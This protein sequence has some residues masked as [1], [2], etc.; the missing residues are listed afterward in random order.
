MQESPTPRNFIADI[1][2]TDLESGRHKGVVT[3]FP[4]EPNGYLH[5]GHAKSI[6]LNF[7]LARAFGGACHLRFDDTNPST[8]DLEYVEAI[9]RDVR[10]LGFDWGPN[11]FFA[12]DYYEA[13]YEHALHLIR[14]GFAY[15]CSLSDAGVKAGRGS[16]SEPGVDSPYRG[17]SVEENLALFERM[18]LGEFEDGAHVLRAKIDMAAANMKL[19]DPAIYRIKHA[20]H[21]RRGKDWC[22][23]P[24]Y[25]FAH[26]LSDAQ[27]GITHSICTLEF[28]NNRELYDW[29]LARSVVD[30]RPRQ[31]EFARLNLTHTL[32]SKRKLLE[33][34]Q[35]G[36]VRGWDDPRMPTIAGMRRRGYTPEAITA[37]CELIGV[38]KNN[39]LVD[40]G[41]LEFCLREDLHERAPR[42]SCVFYPLR[43]TLTPVPKATTLVAARFPDRPE[44]G[45]RLVPLS[46]ELFI[47]RA[48]FSEAPP[49]G[50]H[51]LAPGAEV[52][53]RHAGLL[54]CETVEKDAD[55]TVIALACSYH[56]DD[57]TRK[58]K[59][60]IHWVSAA[61][62]LDVE[63]RLYDKLFGADEPTALDPLNSGSL[64]VIQGC[65]IE[66]S[67]NGT[68]AGA[69]FQF[70]R[71]GYFVSD[72]DGTPERP[73]FNRTVTL[74]DGFAK[75]L[76]AAMP[77]AAATPPRVERPRTRAAQGQAQ[78]ELPR[79][80]AR[81]TEPA[82]GIAEARRARGASDA[83]ALV[84]ATDEALGQLFDGAVELGACASIT[85]NLAANELRGLLGA[86]GVQGLRFGAAELAELVGL[87]DE[88]AVTN[89]TA[90]DVLAHLIAKGGSPRGV[91][92]A[93]G[94]TKLAHGELAAIVSEVVATHAAEATRYREGKTALLAFFVGQVMRRTKG[95]ANPAELEPL[96]RARLVHRIHPI[97]G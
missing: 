16:V 69:H 9:Q 3:R 67:V 68:E 80:I 36:L 7:G 84:F 27:E 92:E 14:T 24:L 46:A 28:E 50:W 18:R 83:A 81:L 82:R 76:A 86:V 37:F 47:E 33:L 64:E 10:W 75:V 32:L 40:L 61:E 22:V 5:I 58:V 29:L 4:P 11:L 39:S 70:E 2:A 35:Q 15:V 96:L 59:G 66:P 8:E 55:G 30:C 31:F 19:R 73:I 87:I 88:G 77:G 21:Y 44:R 42:V 65:K 6:C 48:D 97:E 62:A 78:A 17:R 95:Q 34:V 74:R 1:V 13:L 85:G 71:H 54:R 41:K 20:P 89:T 52:R 91:V 79:S 90:K 45:T 56:E 57:G 49:P 38:A 63:V 72:P 25:D 53:L 94:A 43:V 23:Y 26:C 60:T 51:R 12:S 93:L